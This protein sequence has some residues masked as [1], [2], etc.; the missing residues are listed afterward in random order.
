MHDILHLYQAVLLKIIVT[1]YC[2]QQIN[3]FCW[4]CSLL[5]CGAAASAI[6]F[7]IFCAFR[8]GREMVLPLLNYPHKKI[9][10]QL[11]LRGSGN[12]MILIIAVVVECKNVIIIIIIKGLTIMRLQ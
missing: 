7:F 5:R 11:I 10:L 1:Q 8:S 12:Y 9:C 4:F 2:S 6:P 3:L